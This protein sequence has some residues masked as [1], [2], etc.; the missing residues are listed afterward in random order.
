MNIEKI[1][2]KDFTHWNN[3]VRKLEKE[4]LEFINKIDKK[5]I[6]AK[7]MRKKTNWFLNLFDRCENE[8]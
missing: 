2:K 6:H 1:L 4:R 3:S 8:N 5:I 7:A